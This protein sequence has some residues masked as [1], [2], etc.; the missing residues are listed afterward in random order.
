MLNSIIKFL[1]NILTINIDN[2]IIN[3]SRE[4]VKQATISN[5]SLFFFK[6]YSSNINYFSQRN[7][8]IIL[9]H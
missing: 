9:I 1:L 7:L 4:Y 8:E 5:L 3:I 6:H 2:I